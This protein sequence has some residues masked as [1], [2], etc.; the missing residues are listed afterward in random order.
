MK[1]KLF[2]VIGIVAFAVAIAFNIN[3]NLSNNSEQ[4]LALANIEALAQGELIRG[5]GLCMNIYV[6]TVC[7]YPDNYAVIGIWI[8]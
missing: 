6:N 1:K 7:Y 5:D 8:N 4:N 2:L 3:A